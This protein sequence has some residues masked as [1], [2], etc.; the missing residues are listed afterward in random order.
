[1]HVQEHTKSIVRFPKGRNPPGKMEAIDPHSRLGFHRFKREFYLPR[2][3]P[4]EPDQARLET[5][6]P[7]GRP[8]GVFLLRD[9]KLG[10]LSNLPRNL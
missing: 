5:I 4:A 3:L 6:D 10:F 1:M 9:N 7:A 8:N 2:P